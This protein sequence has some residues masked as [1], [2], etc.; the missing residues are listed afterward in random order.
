MKLAG[1]LACFPSQIERKIFE[2]LDAFCGHIG[3]SGSWPQRR[4]PA[5]AVAGS[6]AGIVSIKSQ[7]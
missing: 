1:K 5:M 6:V 2:H 4:S 7:G 3:L